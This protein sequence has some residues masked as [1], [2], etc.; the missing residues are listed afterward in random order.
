MSGE[1]SVACQRCGTRNAVQR[2]IDSDR[3]TWI[4]GAATARLASD[5][6]L[7]SSCIATLESLLVLVAKVK[8]RRHAPTARPA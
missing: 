5:V 8:K 7:C 2:K 4:F 1:Y 6:R 3:S